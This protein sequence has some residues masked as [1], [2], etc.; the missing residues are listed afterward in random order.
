MSYRLLMLPD[1]RA[2]PVKILRKLKQLVEDGAT[3]AGPKPQRDSGLKNYPQCDKDVQKLAGELWGDCDG[4][5]A[6]WISI[7]SAIA[8]VNPKRRHVL[9]V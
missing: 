2:M 9:F 8:K 7:L 4:A 6:I 5:M 1:T 3:V